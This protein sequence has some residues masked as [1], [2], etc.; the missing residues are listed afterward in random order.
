MYKA[1]DQTAVVMALTD[2]ERGALE[3]RGWCFE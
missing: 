3:G 1:F 2:A